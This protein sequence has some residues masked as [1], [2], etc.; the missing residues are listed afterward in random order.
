[1]K[2]SLNKPKPKITGEGD[3]SISGWTSAAIGK[4]GEVVSHWRLTRFI[5][6]GV[7]KTS[8]QALQMERAKKVHNDSVLSISSR[9]IVIRLTDFEKVVDLS[10]KCITEFA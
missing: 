7:H 5:S 9:V 3:C 8:I 10:S 1:L 6:L 2:G 4:T